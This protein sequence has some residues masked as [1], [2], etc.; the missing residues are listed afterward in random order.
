MAIVVSGAANLILGPQRYFST[1]VFAVPAGAADPTGTA[2][3]LVGYAGAALAAVFVFGGALVKLA[4]VFFPTRSKAVDQAQLQDAAH[5][6][7]D[8]GQFTGELCYSWTPW[9]STD[10]FTRVVG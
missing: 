1:R 6:G 2:I 8:D 5:A 3:Q 9:L 10:I 4:R 7:A